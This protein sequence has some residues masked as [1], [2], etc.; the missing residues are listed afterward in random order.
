M[1]EPCSA[2]SESAHAQSAVR[3][4]RW[5]RTRASARLRRHELRAV[6][7][8][9][10]FLR[11]QPHRF[12]P[13]AAECL[14]A[15]DQL[16][17][18]DGLPFADERQR[19]MRERREISRRA[20]RAAGGHARQHAAVQALEQQLDRLDP[21]ARV[22]LRERV[23]AQQHRGANDRVRIR[24]TD[25]A[26]VRAQQA[27]LELLGQLLGDLLGDE[28]AE[29]RVDAVGVLVRPVRRVLDDRAGGA[30]ARARIVG[31]RR[32]RMPV[33][34]NRPTRRRA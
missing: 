4:S 11:E 7:Q 22:A 29:A 8:G 23:R 26:G 33:D 32:G 3:A 30:H 10:P 28:A 13:D 27:E 14:G 6:D 17:V 25:A 20:D 2:S 34:R 31:Q 9:E 18:D 24:L 1:R 5:A 21:R 16:A 19:E 12:E 15:V